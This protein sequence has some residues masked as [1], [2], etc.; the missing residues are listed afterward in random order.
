MLLFIPSICYLSRDAST[1]KKTGVGWPILVCMSPIGT[2]GIPF[3]RPGASLTIDPY[4][5]MKT[6]AAGISRHPGSTKVNF[7]MGQCAV[8]V[9][10]LEHYLLRTFCTLS[11]QRTPFCPSS[12]HELYSSQ[13]SILS[14][15]HISI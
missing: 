12:T 8:G 2:H 9:D 11:V 13:I 4:S 10:S 14:L 1:R 15:A 7:A 6:A 5:M 3:D